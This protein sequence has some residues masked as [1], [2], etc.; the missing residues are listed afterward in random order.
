MCCDRDARAMKEASD[1]GF[2]A[3]RRE[4]AS[5]WGIGPT[6]NEPRHSAC[7]TGFDC[8]CEDTPQCLRKQGA[9]AC[10]FTARLFRIKSVIKIESYLTR[11]TGPD[12]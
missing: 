2:H 1:G 12:I 6:S 10:A 11:S 3:L 5:R 7:T 9:C 4:S 8:S